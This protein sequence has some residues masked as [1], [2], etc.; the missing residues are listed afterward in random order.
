MIQPLTKPKKRKGKSDRTKLIEKLDKACKQVVYL[1]DKSIC[2]KC[3][4]YVEGANRHA[5]HV[6]P[7]SAGH[8]LRWDVQ[9]IKV[10]CYHDHINW[11]HKNPVESGEWFKTKFPDRYEYLQANR[12]VVK[13]SLQELED[14]LLNLT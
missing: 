3:G 4:K 11:W 13:L 10:L 6:I 8:K 7:V 9:N 1:R 2:Q 5:S 12:G 14:T